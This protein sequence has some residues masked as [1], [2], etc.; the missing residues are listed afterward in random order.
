MH[1]YSA[2]HFWLKCINMARGGIVVL[3]QCSNRLIEN[4]GASRAGEG[5]DILMMIYVQLAAVIEQFEEEVSC[6]L[7]A[8]NVCE[9]WKAWELLTLQNNVATRHLY[10]IHNTRRRHDC[11]TWYASRMPT[12]YLNSYTGAELCWHCLVQC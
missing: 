4:R 9:L 8:K 1:Y 2:S 6:Q 3:L 11:V 5:C 10:V 7:T 12:C